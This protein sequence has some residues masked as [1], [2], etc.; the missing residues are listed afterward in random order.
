M[1]TMAQ[2]CLTNPQT[3]RVPTDLKPK[4][5]ATPRSIIV[6]CHL[7]QDK[8]RAAFNDRLTM[9]NLCCIAEGYVSESCTLPVSGAHLKLEKLSPLTHPKKPRLYTL[10]DLNKLWILQ[11]I[12]K[13]YY[14]YILHFSTWESACLIR[15]PPSCT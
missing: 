14:F 9:I 5:A 6:C 7:Y 13:I 3:L 12:S 4:G 1:E 8:E 15:E 10:R 2:K 11:Q